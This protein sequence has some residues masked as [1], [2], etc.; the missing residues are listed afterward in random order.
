MIAT[1][2]SSSYSFH[3]T[4]MLLSRSH[5]RSFGN[6]GTFLSQHCGDL[7]TLSNWLFD[8]KTGQ[9]FTDGHLQAFRSW[10]W[11]DTATGTRQTHR[12][13]DREMACSSSRCLLVVAKKL[14]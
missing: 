6:C 8:L 5:D 4:N 1:V 13:T 7:V 11:V 14:N 10:A 3:V 12:Q 2:H 9:Q